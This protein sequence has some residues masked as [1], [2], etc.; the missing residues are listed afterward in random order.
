MKTKEK[1][2]TINMQEPGQ[3]LTD[4]RLA[5]LIKEAEK[6]PFTSAQVHQKKMVKWVLENLK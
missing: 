3:L 6:G 4:K 5:K 1:K 2:E